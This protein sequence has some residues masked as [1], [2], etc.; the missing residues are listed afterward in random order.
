MFNTNKKSP[1]LVGKCYYHRTFGHAA[2]RKIIE[3]KDN[4]VHYQRLRGSAIKKIGEFGVC[5][6]FSFRN[7]VHGEV[8]EK[9]NFEA[10]DG[11]DLHPTYIVQNSKGEAIMR[12]TDRKAKW[13]TKKGYATLVDI[14]TIRFV[15]GCTSEQ[16]LLGIYGDLKDNPFF[17]SVKND[18]CCVCGQTYNLTRHHVVPRRHIKKVPRVVSSCISNVLFVCSHCHIAYERYSEKEPNEDIKDP[19]QFVRAW[20]DH[21]INTMKPKFLPEGWDIFTINPDDQKDVA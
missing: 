16:M 1:I 2:V 15:E 11:A 19:V 12:C 18:K 13:Y 17:M 7:W 21:F 20:C 14:A 8:N 9:A 6:I 10:L 4:K 3:I 5:S